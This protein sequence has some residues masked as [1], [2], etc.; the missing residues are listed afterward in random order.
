MKISSKRTH[1]S[2]SCDI[3]KPL[4]ESVQNGSTILEA[5]NLYPHPDVSKYCTLT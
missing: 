3:E 5:S 4:F 1:V 2:V